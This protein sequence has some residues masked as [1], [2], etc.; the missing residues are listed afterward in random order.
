MAATEIKE[1]RGGAERLNTLGSDGGS[2]SIGTQSLIGKNQSNHGHGK[3]L[4]NGAPTPNY[5]IRN[6]VLNGLLQSSS[7][8]PKRTR[9][10]D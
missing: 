5:A 3:N 9:S 2:S 4:K 6:Q 1:R 8:T 7:K 10:K